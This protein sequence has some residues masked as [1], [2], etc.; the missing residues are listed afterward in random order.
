MPNTTFPHQKSVRIHREVARTDFLGIKNENWQAAARDL[1]PHALVLYLYLASNA[2]NYTLALSP[3][4]VREAV[5]MARSTYNDQVQILIDKGYLI[6]SHGN[7]YD[8]Y[9]V[10]QP[11][12]VRNYNDNNTSLGYNVYNDNPRA[13]NEITDAVNLCTA[14][15]REINNST[16]A[17]NND[18]INIGFPSRIEVPKVK[19][20]VISIPKSEGKSRPQVQEKKHSTFEF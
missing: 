16:N 9:E 11:R 19:E 6:L 15:N 10:P 12:A 3:A 4:A 7:T 1:R 2:D 17:I 8:F 14:D 13:V 5:G 20:I 18:K